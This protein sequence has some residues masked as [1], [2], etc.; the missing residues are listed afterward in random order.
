M[1]PSSKFTKNNYF[2]YSNAPQET[3]K[4]FCTKTHIFVYVKNIQRSTSREIRYNVRMDIEAIIVGFSYVGIF[5]LMTAN[6]I[7][8]FPSSQILY[9]LVG[10]FV[11]TGYLGLIPA[12]LIGALGNTAGNV[13]LYELVRA[14]GVHY[15]EKFSIFRKSDI[16]RVQIIFKK[17]GLFFLFIGKL[18]PAIK[19]FIP[20]PAALGRVHRGTFTMLMF[21]SSWIWSL[22]F[23]SIGYFFGKNTGVW[24]SY[25]AILMVIAFFVMFLFYRMI[26]SKEVTAELELLNELPERAPHVHAKGK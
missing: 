14:R 6:G 5:G 19:V 21:S 23:I 12:S 18:L 15:I 4:E 7:F 26:N 20:I 25:G 10:Y 24:K 9:I 8:S 17:K 3:G 11:G 2:P 16:R 13:L 1:L 22:V